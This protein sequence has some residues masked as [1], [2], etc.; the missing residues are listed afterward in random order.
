MIFTA[1][2]DAPIDPL[3]PHEHI[4]AAVNRTNDNGE[5]EGG[6]QP[7]EKISIDEAYESYCTIPAYVKHSDED[8][9]RLLPG[10]QAD[11]MLLEQHPVEAGKTSLNKIKVDALWYKGKMVFDCYH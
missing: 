11:L 8:T 2:S 1:S 5:P 4:F 3:K 9:G 6:W 7:Q 10:Y